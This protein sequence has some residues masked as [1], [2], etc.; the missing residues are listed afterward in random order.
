MVGG[1]RWLI[2]LKAPIINRLNPATVL[3]DAL[4]ALNIYDTYE[5][6][7]GNLLILFIMSVVLCGLSF[8]MVRRECYEQL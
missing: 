1:I 8:F 4:Y 6:F 3:T 2:E 7:T 5:R